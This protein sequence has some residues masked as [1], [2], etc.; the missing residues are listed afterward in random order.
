MKCHNRRIFEKVSFLSHVL[1][2]IFASVFLQNM[3]FSE[4]YNLRGQGSRKSKT[5]HA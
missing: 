4:M 1:T 5:M 3:L 2:N